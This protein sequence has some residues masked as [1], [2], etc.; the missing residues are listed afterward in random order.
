MKINV[1]KA[2]C[3]K[4]AHREA[5]AEISAGLL[6]I[7]PIFETESVSE[8]SGDKTRFVL[9]RFIELGRR[10]KKLSVEQLAEQADIEISE[11]IS[12]ESDIHHLPEPRTLYQ[13]AQTFDV[14][15]TKLMELSGLTKPKD[16]NYLEEAV[17][18]AAR[19]ESIEKLNP[20]EQAA[21]DGL[22]SVLSKK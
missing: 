17:R 11:L 1:T 14:S 7:D 2:W 9:Q 3:E 18:Y 6:A 10:D 21:L 13:L 19:S 15:Q 22:I 8:A 16:V 4:M 5:Y 12:I 20:E